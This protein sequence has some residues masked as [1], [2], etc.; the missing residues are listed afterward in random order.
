[1]VSYRTTEEHAAGWGA[2]CCQRQQPSR[3]T[4]TAPRATAK[5]RSKKLD[6]LQCKVFLQISDPQPCQ[7]H[8]ERRI[9][10]LA[11]RTP[12]WLLHVTSG[13]QRL[14]R[15]LPWL[16]QRPWP[17]WHCLVLSSR[18]R[19]P[20]AGSDR[21]ETVFRKRGGSRPSYLSTSSL[22]GRS[23]KCGMALAARWHRSGRG[24]SH[25]RISWGSFHPHPVFPDITEDA[26]VM[27]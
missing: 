26:R 11:R 13:P 5:T 14:P 18:P 15:P 12:S 8:V 4:G 23:R 2:A 3:T 24:F 21:S 9:Q 16:L 17:T 25:A 6:L 10:N 7:G 1:M 22:G 27:R 20:P 19:Q